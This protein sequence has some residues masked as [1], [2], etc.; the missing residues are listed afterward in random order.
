VP[1]YQLQQHLEPVFRR[2]FSI[3]LMIGLI[4]IF[5]ATEYLNNAI[6]ESTLACGGDLHHVH[7]STRRSARTGI[8][9]GHS[10]VHPGIDQALT[11]AQRTDLP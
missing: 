5:E 3:E 1:L 8:R 7:A 10:P 4:R 2:K 11:Q 9:V 6:H